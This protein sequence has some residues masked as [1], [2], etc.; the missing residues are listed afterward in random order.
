VSENNVAI[1]RALSPPADT[2]LVQ[3]VHD[4][5]AWA[6]RA[7]L[8]APF[9]DPEVEIRV[10]VGMGEA[11]RVYFGF[12]GLRAAFSDWLGPFEEYYIAELETIDCGE[13]VLRLTEHT[14]RLRGSASMVVLR[15]AEVHTFRDGM[16]VSLDTYPD[17]EGGR[18][19]VGQE[20]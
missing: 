9:S 4:D 18:R 10:G 12:D 20:E 3:F 14:G 17:H 13:R 5:A 16:I 15:A 6:A 8:G 7:E 1:V 2:E 19:A 11:T